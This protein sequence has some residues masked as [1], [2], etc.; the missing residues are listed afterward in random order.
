MTT[1][2]RSR[3]PAL[4]EGALSAPSCGCV[5]LR[6]RREPDARQVVGA[7]FRRGPRSAGGGHR[8]YKPG[9]SNIL[10]AGAFPHRGGAADRRGIA[11]VGCMKMPVRNGGFAS[12]EPVC[13]GHG[14]CGGR[15]AAGAVATASC[16]GIHADGHGFGVRDRQ[17][18]HGEQAR[19][20][21]RYMRAGFGKRHCGAKR[22]IPCVTATRVRAPKVPFCPS[23]SA[24]AGDTAWYAA[25]KAPMNEAP[26]TVEGAVASRI[27]WSRRTCGARSV[28]YAA[29]AMRQPPRHRR[30]RPRSPRIL[31]WCGCPGRI[32]VA[33]R[34]LRCRRR[35]RLICRRRRAVRQVR[36][37]VRAVLRRDDRRRP[38]SPKSAGSTPCPYRAARGGP[39]GRNPGCRAGRRW[40]RR[41]RRRRGCGRPTDP[42]RCRS[43]V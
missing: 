19:R 42:V 24:M 11:G 14:L 43:R 17:Q 37:R 6:R 33:G 39:A 4:D 38:L 13:G 16:R 25:L 26:A 7:Q 27:L 18:C 2:W 36:G 30:C 21:H 12:C 23:M 1:V 29:V 9:I 8:L 20:F 41:R 40:P 34:R 22:R 32:R 5:R 15:P 10:P 35:L 3:L 28:P 31:T